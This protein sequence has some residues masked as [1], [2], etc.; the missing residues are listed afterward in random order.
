MAAYYP[1]PIYTLSEKGQLIIRTTFEIVILGALE[2]V[3]N[4][5]QL[6]RVSAKDVYD[7]LEV[8]FADFSDE[9]KGNLVLFSV[10]PS[11]FTAQDIQF[12]F[13]DPLLC[14]T[15][16]TRMVKYALLQRDADGKMRMHPLVQAY[17]RTENESPGK[18]DMWRAT[19][20]KFNHHYLGQLR[21]LG[22]DFISKDSALVAI[23][24]ISAEDVYNT[25]EV[26]FNTFSNEV[27]E[28]LVLFSVFPSE[29]IPQDVQFLFQDLLHCETAKTRMVKYALLQKD[30]DGKM[31]MHPLI[32][33]YFRT[34]N[35]SLGMGDL[36]RTTQ[37]KFNHHYLDQLRVLSEE[38]ISK[39]SALDA[40]RKF[41]QQKAN[42]MEALKN[43]LE[44]SSDLD[45]KYF[46]L[47]VVNGTEVLDFVA[48]VLT[49]PKECTMLYQKCCD[50]AKA[51]GDKKRHAESLNSL[52]FRRLCDVAHSRDSPEENQVTLAM[53][54]EAYDMRRTLPEEE[55]KSQ[56]HAHTASKLGVCFVLQG[57]EKKGRKLIQEGISIRNS[58]RGCLYVA[59]GY[60]DLGNSYRLCGDHQEAI[61]I[62]K[63]NTLPVYQEQ[64]GDHPWT[65]SILSFIADST[66]K[67]LT[68]GSPERGDI[69]QAEMYFREAQGLRKR[70]LGHH[71]DTA[72]SCVQLSDVLFLQGQFDEALEELNEAFVIQKDIL[73]P[74]HK[75]TKDTA[76][77]M[78]DDTARSCVQ[79]SDVLVL[80][81]QFDE[82]LEELNKA[83]EIQK[84]VLGP[85]HKI[86]KNTMSKMSDVMDKRASNPR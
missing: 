78:S 77:K 49:P 46:V 73:G 14:E 63:K 62:W 1:T 9:V 68:T 36:W 44:D 20:R 41:R 66:Y 59:A 79:V 15:V 25:L 82:A 24:K 19:Q 39:D 11:E 29:F 56:T 16:K 38:F 58:L 37:R 5:I 61:D 57:E 26:F 3:K 31:R 48:K 17:F 50:I 2:L 35:E 75:I 69:N 65:A 72:R 83:F 64:L 54:Q 7:T 71:Q 10:F 33:A 27:K 22:E 53:F 52:G 70:L 8:F 55:Q 23:L 85:D 67:A 51:S 86:T 34:E 12:L 21:V 4:P 42:I 6:L 45:D 76:R 18:G 47:D 80:Q 81:G 32:Q 13:E 60:C 43:C 84:D 28:N 30:A 40:I 74:E